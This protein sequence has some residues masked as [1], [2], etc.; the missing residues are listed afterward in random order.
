MRKAHVED[1]RD[2]S[3]IVKKAHHNGSVI[4]CFILVVLCGFVVVVVVG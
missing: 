1:G 4:G 2:V 3:V